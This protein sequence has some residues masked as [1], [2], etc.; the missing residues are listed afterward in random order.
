MKSQQAKGAL[1]AELH[2]QPDAF[3]IPNP[4]DLGTARILQHAGFKALATTSAGHA[5]AMGLP[6]GK[7]SRDHVMAHIYTLANGVDLPL[8]AD[9][10]NGFS[11]EPASS[12]ECI[13]LASGAG[14]V[15]GSIEDT[16]GNEADPIRSK[17]HAAECVRAAAEAAGSLPHPF[18]L[19]ARAENFIHGPPDL[20]D[21]IERLQCYQEAG[22]DVLYAPGLRSLDE[23]EVVVRS[24]DRPVNVLAGLGT[25][26]SNLAEL[27]EIGVKRVSVGS[28]LSRLVFGSLFT[29][30]REMHSMGSFRFGDAGM[31]SA[32]LNAIFEAMEG[33]HCEER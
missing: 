22:A 14:A 20:K 15:G 29:A 11:N 26:R 5:F 18:L 30:V 13:L 16:T 3:I 28:A 6:D 27:Q 23:I 19:T 21:T 4:W 32:E 2:R 8:S 10:Q 31:S 7:V 33:S 12:A 25:L 1:F 9:L 17:A 24:V